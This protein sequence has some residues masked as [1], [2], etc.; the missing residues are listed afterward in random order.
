MDISPEYG[1]FPNTVSGSECY[2]AR[3]QCPSG[4]EFGVWGLGSG[5]WDLGFGIGG[6]GLGVGGSG[7]WGFGRTPS[8]F[9][10][11]LDM[12]GLLQLSRV[13]L[14]PDR[15]RLLLD[16]H[17]LLPEDKCLLASPLHILQQ[18]P[19]RVIVLVQL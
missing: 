11:L 12:L 6:G 1:P 5:G 16:Q 18:P 9:Q 19:R 17:L 13:I 8:L 15:I 7:V 2:C 14:I 4:L 10:Q 3:G